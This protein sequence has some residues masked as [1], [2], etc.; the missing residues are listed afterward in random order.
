VVKNSIT[1]KSEFTAT[2]AQMFIIMPLFTAE[3]VILT[4]GECCLKKH[5]AEI[6]QRKPLLLL[7]LGNER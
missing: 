6:T 5:G 1:Q 2:A 4:D 7:V 3:I